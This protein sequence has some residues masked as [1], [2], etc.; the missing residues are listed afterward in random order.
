MVKRRNNKSSAWLWLFGALVCLV[1][2]GTAY[3]VVSNLGPGVTP[4]KKPSPTPSRVRLSEQRKIILYLPKETGDGFVLVPAA[5]TFEGKGS[6]LDEAV[7]ELLATA[8]QSGPVGN[9]IPKGTRLLSPVKIER[10]V[11]VL[12]LS[13]ELVDNFAGGSD[14]EAL[15]LNSIVATVVDNSE[16]KADRV[17]IEVDGKTVESLGGHFDLTVPLTPDPE[18]VKSVKGN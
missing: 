10:D 3:Y 9:L 6:I 12:N 1:A 7:R 13:K 14:L 2:A 4:P 18:I 8:G 17:R 5:R 16:G 15:T 11:A